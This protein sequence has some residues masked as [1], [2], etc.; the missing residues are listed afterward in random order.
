MNDERDNL[1]EKLREIASGSRRNKTARLREIFDDIEAAKAAGASNKTIVAELAEHK[2]IF[3]VNN[4]KNAR[5][6][7]L[8]ERA[9]EALAQAAS[10]SI[11]SVSSKPTS[12]NKGSKKI[13]NISGS[14]A[15]PPKQ[16]QGEVEQNLVAPKPVGNGRP[17]ILSTGKKI[18]GGLKPSPIDGMVDLNQKTKGT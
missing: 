13:A 7:I 12:K 5:S 14:T 9:M 11:G 4:F 1:V 17:S 3:D 10:K 15:L 6:R 18:F 16:E 2:L 8:K